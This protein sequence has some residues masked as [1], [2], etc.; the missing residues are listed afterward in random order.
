MNRST[1]AEK[2]CATVILVVEVTAV[3]VPAGRRDHAKNLEVTS[4]VNARVAANLVDLAAVRVDVARVEDIVAFA[5]FD[6]VVVIGAAGT[7]TSCTAGCPALCSRTFL[8]MLRVLRDCKAAAYQSS[9][10]TNKSGRQAL[11]KRSS[12]ARHVPGK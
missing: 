7:R 11:V 3:L 4:Q 5:V 8:W 6:C 12:S 2:L 9:K 1:E 10:Q